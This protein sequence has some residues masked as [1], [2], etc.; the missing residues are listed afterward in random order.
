MNHISLTIAKM[1]F[2]KGKNRKLKRDRN[3]NNIH[4]QTI[5]NEMVALLEIDIPQE[6]IKGSGYR[7]RGDNL[8]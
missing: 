8:K 4:G 2:D 3:D 1:K 7:P 5:W 6:K